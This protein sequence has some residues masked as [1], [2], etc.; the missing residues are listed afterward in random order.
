SGAADG[1]RLAPVGLAT[2]EERAQACL[3]F[4]TGA[5]PGGNPCGLLAVG[6]LADQPL[7][8][9]YGLWPGR[10]QLAD[11]ALDRCV[12]IVDHL[13]HE[14]DPERRRGVEALAG[15]EVTPG[16]CADLRQ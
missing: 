14:S 1:A 2:F 12:E 3:P 7:R 13:V 9:A 11:D 6:T 5:Q 4:R 10:E 16:V 8:L 15:E